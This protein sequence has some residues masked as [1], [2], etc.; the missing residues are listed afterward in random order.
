M[1]SPFA[2]ASL[3]VGDL[4]PDVTEG[5][6]FEL[7]NSI[8]QVAS[9][10]VCRDTV[11]RRSLGYAYVNFHNVLD[12]E[13]ALDSVSNTQI[14]G[15]F[16]RI[17][18]SQRDP[19]LRKSGVGNVFI[20]NLDK[21]I[22]HKTLQ[23]TFSSFGNIL[24]CKTATD[25]NGNSK[26]YGFVHFET[27]AMAEKAIS[28][29]NG[30]MIGG[31]KVFVGPFLPRKER[32]TANDEKY[33]NVYVKNLDDSVDEKTIRQVF[34]SHGPI[35]SAVIML[36]PDGK[37][38][39]FGFINF[40]NAEDAANAVAATNGQ[41]I[42][43]NGKKI[44]AGKAQKKSKREAEL[45]QKFEQ[46]RL[47]RVA[48]YQGMNLYIKNLDDDID[49]EKLKAEF[50]PY[51]SIT[52]CKI[53]RDEKGHSKGFGF[54]CFSSQD[55]A[56]RA[57]TELNGKMIGSK[58]LYVALAQRKEVRKAQLEAQY[59]ARQKGPGAGLPLYPP[60][61]SSAVFY[62][63]AGFVYPQMVPPRNRW[64]QPQP[65]PAAFMVPPLQQHGQH[66]QAQ[67]QPRHG[68]RP[69]NHRR[70]YNTRGNRDQ[71][72]VQQPISQPQQPPIIDA[73]PVLDA[74][75]L[76]NILPNY[77]PEQQ[78]RIV[79]ERLYPLIYKLQPELSGK[80]TGM[81]LDRYRDEGFVE[82]LAVM[83]NPDLLNTK[84]SEALEVLHNHQVQVQDQEQGK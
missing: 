42:I 6:L 2:S 1:P 50:A 15:K 10:R 11:T 51:G 45:K 83:E 58:P 59:A 56:T 29:V 22:D 75:P 66:G 81:L 44:F 46:L 52:S 27:Q 82:L 70:G 57:L 23:D 36:G 34:G 53:M 72:P 33:T 61:G 60:G 3:Y 62:P 55:E 19:S 20:K 84:V 69:F 41:S 79:G 16:C 48:K 68:T 7:F 39:C 14:K 4:H 73:N 71:M 37:S 32:S 9:V 12:A 26:G 21:R 47:E 74:E 35:T 25:E 13:R 49:D 8:G 5:Q 77:S 64:T 38:K 67:P 80:I 54:V 76:S 65:V 40:E 28:K 17:M 24:S 63:G 78:L 43:P 31:Q 18:W 30:M